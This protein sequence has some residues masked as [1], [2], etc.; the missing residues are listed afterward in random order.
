MKK[1]EKEDKEKLEALKLLNDKR[2]D[3]VHVNLKDLKARQREQYQYYDKR[4]K[5][6]IG[7]VEQVKTVLKEDIETR[8]ELSLLRKAD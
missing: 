8:K 4:L 2:N 3:G 5:E 6:R 1:K 7:K